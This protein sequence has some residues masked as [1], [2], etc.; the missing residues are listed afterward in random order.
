MAVTDEHA[1]IYRKERRNRQGYKARL[2]AL[3][4]RGFVIMSRIGCRRAFIFD[5]HF[6]Q[7]GFE[8]LPDIALQRR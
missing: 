2:K 1:T 4:E 5:S 3:Q 6:R 7:M 8:M